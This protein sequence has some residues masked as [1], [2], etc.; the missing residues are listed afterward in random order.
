MAA[1]CWRQGPVVVS[2]SRL[3]NVLLGLIVLGV[4][5]Y[6]SW[7]YWS[8]ENQPP[9]KF[10]SIAVLNKEIK[11]GDDLVIRIT[12]DRRRNCPGRSDRFLIEL[13]GLN[14]EAIV[15]RD[16]VMIAPTKIGEGVNYT[17]TMPT[18]KK[19]DPGTYVFRGNNV[20]DCNGR[21]FV[22][23]LPEAG[24]EVK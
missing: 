20:L 7:V 21:E 8:V 16:S 2:L 4:A 13:S 19:L 12:F 18:P 1:Q 3:L 17:F 11:A 15:Y 5:T 24:F 10:L 23:Q 6:F 9:V 14:S 22:I